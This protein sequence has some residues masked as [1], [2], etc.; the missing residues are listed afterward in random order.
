M[1]KALDAG[2]EEKEEAVGEGEVVYVQD[3]TVLTRALAWRQAKVGLV[4][5]GT[6][7]VIFMSEV[8]EEGENGELAASVAKDF[9]DGLKKYWGVDGQVS[10]LGNAEGKLSVEVNN[11]FF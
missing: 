8:L 4:G 1:F 5:E 10:I 6:N 9:V 2:I 11:A 3:Q 7:N